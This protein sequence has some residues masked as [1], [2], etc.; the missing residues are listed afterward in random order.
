[1]TR[2]MVKNDIHDTVKP[3]T[4]TTSYAFLEGRLVP[5]DQAKISIMTHGFL[6]GTAIFEGIRAYYNEKQKELYIFR[7]AEHFERL[8]TN[9]K[10][11]KIEL[12]YTVDQLVELAVEM[13]RKSEFREDVYLR[14][15]GYKSS[16]RIGLK[17]DDQNE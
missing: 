12:A 10:I 5:L 14:P 3:S 9:C 15:V 7:L 2:T 6:Y 4:Q 16:L 11:I 1:M 17:L 8:T 13:V